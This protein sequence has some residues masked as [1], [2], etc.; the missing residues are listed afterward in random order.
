[1]PSHG[2]EI[3][4]GRSICLILKG[5]IDSCLD[6]LFAEYL[7][8]HCGLLFFF[9]NTLSTILGVLVSQ[10]RSLLAIQIHLLTSRVFIVLVSK[11]D[12]L[13]QPNQ[14]GFYFDCLDSIGS[15]AVVNIWII[16]AFL[17]IVG[18]IAMGWRSQLVHFLVVLVEDLGKLAQYWIFDSIIG[19]V[20]FVHSK[21]LLF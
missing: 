16:V 4:R 19:A 20:L 14:V 11:F 2:Q 21:E 9:A 17:F 7:W 12:L 15:H 3:R 10:T 18:V 5:V 13:S 6:F 8:T 1:V